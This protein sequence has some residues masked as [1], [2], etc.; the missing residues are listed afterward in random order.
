VTDRKPREL[1]LGKHVASTLDV[2]AP[3]E[4]P[5]ERNARFNRNWEELKKARIYALK[6]RNQKGVNV[7]DQELDAGRGVDFPADADFEQDVDFEPDSDFEPDPQMS[8][9]RAQQGDVRKAEPSMALIEQEAAERGWN[10]ANLEFIQKTGGVLKPGQ[11]QSQAVSEMSGRRDPSETRQD[12]EARHAIETGELIH[13]NS[14]VSSAARPLASIAGF[15]AAGPVGATAA[16]TVTAAISIGYNVEQAMQR[17]MDPDQASDLF[18]DEMVK[19]VGVDAAFN[20][21]VPIIGSVLAKIPGLRTLGSKLSARLQKLGPKARASLRDAKIA[22]RKALTDDPARKQAVDALTSRMD[23]GYL[24]TKGQ[25]S[26]KTGFLERR[27]YEAFPGEFEAAE[28]SMAKGAEQLRKEVVDP[29]SQPAPQQIGQQVDR[30]VDSTVKAVKDRLRPVFQAANNANMVVDMHDVAA[31][32]RNALA[33]NSEVM[34]GGKLSA[35]EIKH[36]QKILADYK[37]QPWRSAEPT[38]DFLSVQKQALRTLN[39]DGKPTPYF[40]TIVRDMTKSA[41]NAYEEG[42]RRMGHG[43]LYKKLTQ[44]WDDYRVMNETAYTGAM[45]QAQMK[46]DHAAEEIAAHLTAKGKVT[47]IEELDEMLKMGLREGV[48]SPQAIEKMRRNVARA[49][50]QQNVQNLDQAA[51]WSEHL[52]D[53]GRRATWAALTNA[54]GGKELNEAMKVLEQAAQIATVPPANRQSRFFGVPFSRAIGGGLGFSWVTGAI[55]PVIAGL[56]LSAAGAMRLATTAFTHGDKGT[57]NLLSKVI[58]SNNAGTAASAKALETLLPQLAEAAEK[59]GEDPFIREEVGQAAD[60]VYKASDDPLGVR[61]TVKR[62][63]GGNK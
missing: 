16:D 15:A 19:T 2:D 41:Q 5:E 10:N 39:K 22:E 24:P 46:G 14:V 52:K 12:A 50:V 61:A 60:A 40:E 58:R 25:V 56:G 33:K 37:K 11:T 31:V 35:D 18:W 7:L 9:K 21:G 8:A 34:G 48:A 27:G 47:R 38:L 59:Y 6:T 26:G 3:V 20:F 53:P 42:A 57:L 30:F 44:A 36:L 28:R 13:G 1:R 17:G 23:D 54:P 29:R 63:V 32:A 49:Y 43:D 45:K 4:T 51:K 55:S 62:A